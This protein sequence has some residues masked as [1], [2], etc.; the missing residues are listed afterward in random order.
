MLRHIFDNVY[1]TKTRKR[2]IRQH[3]GQDGIADSVR[4]LLLSCDPYD[5]QILNHLLIPF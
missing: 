5:I 1:A 3:S 2:V 4:Q